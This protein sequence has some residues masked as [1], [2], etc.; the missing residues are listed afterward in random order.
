MIDG[1]KQRG[2]DRENEVSGET[3]GEKMAA[4]KW[5]EG[6]EKMTGACYE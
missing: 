2:R 3:R 6:K 4:N 1:G 5:K